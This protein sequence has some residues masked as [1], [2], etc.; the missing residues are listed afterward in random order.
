[1][2]DRHVDLTG[3]GLGVYSGTFSGIFR[4]RSAG[5]TFGVTSFACNVN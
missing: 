5:S 4:Q 1:V 2:S 3:F